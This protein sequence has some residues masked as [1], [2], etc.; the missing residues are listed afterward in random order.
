MCEQGEKEGCATHVPFR[1]V[2]LRATLGA[3]ALKPMTVLLS[4]SMLPLMSKWV[5][6]VVVVVE[7]K[8]CVVILI[9]GLGS[10]QVLS[11]CHVATLDSAIRASYTA[12][13]VSARLHDDGSLTPAFSIISHSGALDDLIQV[14]YQDVERFIILST[15]PKSYGP[16]MSV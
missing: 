11:R 10:A 9:I 14:I 8:Q 7:V 3:L 13:R 6:W 15:T 2:A 5:M 1:S 12:V 4:Q 16:Y